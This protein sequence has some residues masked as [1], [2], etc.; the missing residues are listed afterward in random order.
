MKKIQNS[1]FLLLISCSITLFSQ[2]RD[3]QSWHSVSIKKKVVKKTDFIFKS[4]VRFRENS[5]IF[6]K[7]YFDFKIRKKL[8]KRFILSSGYRYSL[9]LNQERNLLNSHRIYSD[10]N[11]KNKIIKRLNYAIRNRFQNQFNIYESNF[12]FRQKFMISYNIR[13]TKITPN[14]ATEY[15]YKLNENINKL[16]STV[17][18]SYPISKNLGFDIYYRIQQQFHVANPQ[19]IFIFEGKISYEL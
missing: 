7:Q 15:F 5:R 18:F 19:T 12:I 14:F 9:N 1:I 13:K 8:N 4:S 2:E 16:R 3:F 6:S 10:L 11:F 17:T